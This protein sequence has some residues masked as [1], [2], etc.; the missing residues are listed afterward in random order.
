MYVS[1]TIQ[2]L[3]SAERDSAQK[4]ILPE[5]RYKIVTVLAWFKDERGLKKRYDNLQQVTKSLVP[6]ERWS[7]FCP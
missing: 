6:L 1:T 2:T 3:S 4:I 5:E 7:P